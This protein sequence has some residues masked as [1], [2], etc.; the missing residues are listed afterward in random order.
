MTGGVP[1]G[2]WAT[3]AAASLLLLGCGGGEP[4]PEGPPDITGTWVGEYRYPAAGTRLV[5]DGL[6]VI[7]VERFTITSQDGL[8]IWGYQTWV[9][10]GQTQRDLL[11]GSWAADGQSLVLTE[12]TGF[13]TG[14]FDGSALRL[15]FIRTGK[16]RT[17]YEVTL[18]LQDAAAP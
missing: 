6:P 9:D 16:Q 3:V 4:P 17:T 14:T 12:A 10:A 15:R 1:G 8:L 13:W 7:G 18:L 5:P 2:R 11:N